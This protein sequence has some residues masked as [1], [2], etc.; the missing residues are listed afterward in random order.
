[1]KISVIISTYNRPDALHA[2]LTGFCHQ[3]PTENDWE[4]IVADDGSTNETAKTINDFS[5]IDKIHLQH[6]WHEDKGFRLA[7][8]RNLAVTRSTGDYLVFLDG[9]C[10]PLPDFVYQHGWLAERGWAIAGNRI[11]MS[12]GFTLDY[13]S[14]SVISSH[15]WNKF[16]WLKFRVK[17]SVN[18][19]LGWLRIGSQAW[20]KQKAEN[21]KTLRGCNIG[22]WRNDFEAIHGFDATFSGWGY[23]DSD[24]AVRLIRNGVGIKNGRFSV[25]VLHLWHKENDRSFSGENWKKFEATLSSTHT[26]AKSGIKNMSHGERP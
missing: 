26:H 17:K 1:M 24:L 19:S 10:I 16:D 21:W 18:N 7:E 8:I 6:V 9:D 14:G 15:L 12:Q 13:L 22:I 4:I 11:L 20:R 25:P 3:I 2:V 23:E 5:N